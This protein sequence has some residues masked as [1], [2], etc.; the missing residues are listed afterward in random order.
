[1]STLSSGVGTL[2]PHDQP[3]RLRPRGEVDSLG[4]PGT[5]SDGPVR[6]DGLDPVLF[7]DEDEGVPYSLVNGESDGEVAIA[8]HDGLDEPVGGPSR[9][10]PHQ[11]RVEHPIA[12]VVGE[13][14]DLVLIEH[15]RD[16]MEDPIA[17]GLRFGF[18][19]CGAARM[20]EARCRSG[21][22]PP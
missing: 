22:M 18:G 1:M 15:S 19:Q 10:G 9:V 12:M 21:A 2:T 3:S 8:G 17:Y 14:A 11:D 7:L 20:I 16:Y 6:L 13:M 5:V 4:D